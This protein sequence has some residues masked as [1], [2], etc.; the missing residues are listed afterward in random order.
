MRPVLFWC[1]LATGCAAGLVVLLMSAT[2]VLLA[3]EPWILARVERDPLPAAS[4][5]RARPEALVSRAV[6]LES[7]AKPTAVV[8]RAD[9][10][11]A[12]IVLFG[13]QRTVLFGAHDGRLLD[14]AS[15]ARLFFKSV[16]DLHRWLGSKDFGRP[17][18]G[19]ANLAFL[20]LVCSGFFLWWPRKGGFR[21]SAI[22]DGRLKGRAK[23]WN[24][25]NVFG[26]WALPMLSIIT[27]S[28]AVMSYPWANALL[29]RLAGSPAPASAA[30]DSGRK[31]DDG[32][33]KSKAKDAPN[34][35]AAAAFAGLDALW[36]AA[37]EKVPAWTAITLRLPKDPGS[38]ASASIEV[39]GALGPPH[40]YNLTIDPETKAILKWEPYETHSRGQ[41]WRVWLRFLHT[42]E[43]LAI[44][45]R[46]FAVFA[47]L[48]GCV[49]V[50]TGFA[51]ALR[52]LRGAV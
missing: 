45:G 17:I 3:F 12:A 39:R 34:P 14:R 6:G 46:A 19:A 27:V 11:S 29:Y 18:T 40:R 25:H 16:E 26:L 41:R 43:A 42:G 7:A 51:M 28:G 9:P 13:S 33:T 36:D 24:R 30:A 1:H 37:R 20:G 52:R 35:A 44:P 48:A 8:L 15:R 47:S 2:G 32:K 21:K 38:P 22:L 49:L 50:W 10:Q 4:S 5:E 31:R 23:D